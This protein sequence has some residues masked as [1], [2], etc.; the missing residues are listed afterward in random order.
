MKNYTISIGGSR[1]A[2]SWPRSTVSWDDI[3]NRIQT[4]V[5]GTEPQS[6]YFKMPKA[7]QDELKDVGGFVGGT[8][9]GDQRKAIAVE[10]RDLITLDLDAIPAHGT[11]DILSKIGKLGCAAAVYSTRKHC[12]SR[13]RLRVLIP[14]DRTCTPDE[15]EPA[16]RKVAELI[17]ISYCDPTTFQASRL[18]YWPSCSADAEYVCESFSG[19]ECR[20]DGIL[21]MFEDWKDI[22][23]WPQV[24]GES[25]LVRKKITK[26]E[27]PEE[28]KGI[29]GAF[30]RT[31]DIY[32]AMEKFIPGAYDPV[33]GQE[34][35]TYIGG[36][37]TGGAVVYD[38]GLFLYS[39]H[40]TDPCS[41]ELV[42]AF[43][44]VRLHKFY[45]L[46]ADVDPGTKSNS[47]P[48]F[49]AMCELARS[50]EKVMRILSTEEEAK[51]AESFAA[52]TTGQEYD[53]EWRA[54]LER[55]DSGKILGTVENVCLI[56]RNDI[57]LRGRIWTDSFAGRMMLNLPVPWSKEP[58]GVRMWKD[59]DD[60][61]LYWYIER[62]Y[63]KRISVGKVLQGVNLEAEKQSF[64]PLA[65]Y[66]MKLEWD[67]RKR[68]DRILI[69]YLGAEDTE[70]VRVVT[71]KVLVAAVA[72]VLSPG[73]KFDNMVI[74]V[75]Q[76]GLG[77]STLFRKLGME[78]FTD[79]L[80]SFDGKDAADLIQGK[81]IVE[82]GELTAMTRQ[83]SNS[84]KQ[85]LSKQDDTYRAAYGR[86]TEKHIRQCI[87]VGTSNDSEFLKDTTGNRRFWPVEVGEDNAA[88][89][90]F[91]GLTQD[92]IDQIWAEAVM[93]FRLGESLYLSRKVEKMAEEQ[94]QKHMITTG[95][96]G[97][98]EAFLRKPIPKNWYDLNE[99]QMRNFY[100]GTFKDVKT[101]DLEPRR[102]VCVSE[103]W[104]LCLGYPIG[105]IKR[106]DSVEIVSTMKNIAGW[107]QNKNPMYFGNFG[108][109]KGFT[110]TPE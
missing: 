62:Y 56:I 54:D 63:T 15:Y 14:L 66:L 92:I 77:K 67:G 64:N 90:V 19:P 23:E 37:T 73:C 1:K 80:T 69:D 32:S 71:R 70:Y 106:L 35:F 11:N 94:Q 61:G 5:R 6:D 8:F 91:E 105:R 38:N 45:D 34:R 9:I 76:Q 72:R 107:N 22:Q 81:W 16:A 87:F 55:D 110:C 40:A 47:L 60:N 30:C 95:K 44:L 98:V 104:T 109:Q 21:G 51:I 2:A 89:D 88:L 42:N 100:A 57:N 48:S 49:K 12:P 7:K 53:P 27:N 20:V 68:S 78:W 10:G 50:D 28:K 65:D 103:I 84:V 4:P 39:H 82:V 85:F 96:E 75:G 29:V 74:L 18:M 24:P 13:P 59:V 43:D 102:K 86:R 46:D 31:Y 79:S 26:Q 41:E 25:A 108:R 52:P 17:G 58:E 99:D 36:S 33:D 83:E 93:R 97:L 101:E 3:L